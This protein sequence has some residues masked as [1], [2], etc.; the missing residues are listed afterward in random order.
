MKQPE[1]VYI[2]WAAYDELSDNVELTETLA[3]RQ[4][5][6]LLRL[7]Q[8]GVRLDYYLMDAFWYAPDGGYRAWRQPHWP[9]GPERWLDTC[10]ANGVKPGLWLATNALSKL[11][12]A[13]AW[14]SSLN[15][16]RRAMCLFQGGF[17][18]DLIEVMQQWY[19]RGVRMY[20]FDFAAFDA[21]TP[22]AE[23]S[24]RPD[25]IRELN[26][27]AFR[28]AL[29]RFREQNPEVRLLAYNGFGGQQSNT[30][31]PFRKTVDERWLGVFDS[32]YCGDP[33]PADV[34]AMSFWRSKDVYSDHMVR[35]YERNGIA[36]ER[37]DNTAFMIGTTGTCYHRRTA[38]WRGMLVL[39][40]ARGG[41]MN[42]FYGNLEL[43]DAAQ[44]AWFAKVQALFLRFQA[45]GRIRT[46]GGTP[47]Q[48]EPYGYAAVN[49]IGALF[50]VVNPAQQ[51]TEF[52]LPL[53]GAGPGGTGAGR[54]LF[55]DAGFTPTLRAG[56]VTLGPEQLAVVGF[57]A[58]AD[59]RYDLGVEEDVRI[60]QRIVAL[61]TAFAETAHNTVSATLLP[62]FGGDLRIVLTQSE[63]GV[64]VRSSGTPTQSSFGQLLR[65]TARQAE[66]PLAVT[67]NYDKVIWSGLSWAVGEIHAGG[68]QIGEPL[69]IACSSAEARKLTLTVTVYEI[70]GTGAV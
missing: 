50:T 41:W 67:I 40:L 51:M 52:A 5:Q 58:Y 21:A 46:F 64:A 53:A 65:I 33:R 37:I 49:E 45:Y 26:A 31:L 36:L 13:P 48:S 9:H 16:E 24:L 43:L 25:E 29:A 12:P 7:R 10:L 68:I 14:E 38:A 56:S 22:E 28:A 70:A 20:K 18:A 54:V 4:L 6:E 34:P 2:N 59:P 42:T 1:F 39:S 63:N 55:R 15:R 32:L 23:R 8:H 66:K 69:Q 17:L 30:S 47:G 35:D 62:P 27:G 61:P 3:M 44:A 60:P 11:Q 19:D 57:G